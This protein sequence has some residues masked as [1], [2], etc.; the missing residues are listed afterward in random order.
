MNKRLAVVALCAMISA[1]GAVDE[2]SSYLCA[3][4]M[5]TGFILDKTTG[6]W[7]GANFRATQKYVVSRSKTAKSE[8]EGKEIGDQLPKAFCISNLATRNGIHRLCSA[9]GRSCGGRFLLVRV[10]FASH[11][12]GPH[13]PGTW[14]H[15]GWASP[16]PYFGRGSE[17][18]WVHG[19]SLCKHA[20]C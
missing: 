5:A 8:W 13:S 17:L 7:H 16:H 2:P 3:P 11:G 1:A 9:K 15:L 12:D 19:K 20:P 4:D 6:Q 14:F 18:S 10:C